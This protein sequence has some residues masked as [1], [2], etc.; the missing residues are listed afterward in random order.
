MHRLFGKFQKPKTTKPAA[1]LDDAST[2]V[3]KRGSE[4]DGRIK[5]LDDELMRYKQQLAKMRDSPAKKSLQQRA[6]KVLQ[7]KKLYEKQRDSIMSKQF[8]IDQTKYAQASLKDTVV[9]VDAMRGAQKE[10]KQ[11]FKAVNVDQVEDLH[12]DM[13]EMMEQNEE[14]QEVMGRTYGVPEQL[15]EGDLMNE[16][17]SLEDELATEAVTDETPSYLVNAATAVKDQKDAAPVA[18]SAA[19]SAAPA[20]KPAVEV[21]MYGMPKVPA[22][23]LYE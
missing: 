20:G 18:V 23:K 14:I 19:A 10:L 15:D 13:S 8:N 4:V 1:T 12:E 9:M 3:E 21:D 16:L 2:S 17:N 11:Q 5:K 7:Q 22:R 6:L